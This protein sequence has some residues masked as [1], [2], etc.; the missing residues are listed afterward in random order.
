[1][2]RVAFGSIARFLRLE[3]AGG[4]VLIAAALVA[5]VVS[6]SPLASAYREAL[7]LP[8]E[9]RAGAVDLA[10]P[11]YLWINDGLM[12]VFFLLVGLEIKREVMQGELASVAQIGLPVIAA[13]G[14][15]ALPAALYFWLTRG[16]TTA[17]KG[18]A[19]PMATD[20][21]FALG[22]ISLLGKRVPL[23]L[24]VFLAAIAI[25]DD[26]GSILVI[27]LVYT[28]QISMP[29]LL[30]AGGAVLSLVALNVLKVRTLAAYA[31]AGVLLWFF[32]L[33]SGIQPTIA[34]VILAFTI[35]LRV[36]GQAAPSP[37]VRLEHGLHPW[38]AFG[39]LPVFAFANAGVA[40]AGIGVGTLAEPVPL[41]IVA[42][43]VVG[44]LLGVFASSAILIKLGFARLPME[45]NWVS[46]CGVAALCGIGFTMSL[47][48]G[49]LAFA[50]AGERYLQQV[51]LGVLCGSVLSG[52]VGTLFLGLGT[53][54]GASGGSAPERGF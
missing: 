23:S 25:A 53:K 40:L 15:M 51:R 16:D 27:A 13:L 7:S 35:P 44:K 32:V 39:V 37:L 20:I 52:T 50:D 38:V 48:I 54:R 33:K 1:M 45:S 8:L 17:V 4:L 21:A 26:L 10:K 18:W 14:G 29:M 9:I 30:L 12:V 6:N 42:G 5:L 2:Y 3:S 47:F 34:G 41:G 28:A 46:L 43:L 49:G 24:K 31:F 11:V 36:D 19:I 22:I